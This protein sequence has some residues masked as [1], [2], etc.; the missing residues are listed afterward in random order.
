MKGCSARRISRLGLRRR[1]SID[2]DCG[3]AVLAE[4]L[5]VRE[6]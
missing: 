2:R 5:A 1:L 4:D 3:D 6:D